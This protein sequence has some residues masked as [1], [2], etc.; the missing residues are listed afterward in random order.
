M[1]KTN[2]ERGALNMPNADTLPANGQRIEYLDYLRVIA[3]AAVVLLHISIQ[4]W[5]DV[6]V[7]SG[8]WM[9]YNVWNG[10]VRWCVPVF[11]MISGALFLNPKKKVSV[12]RLWTRN[13][14]R[15]LTAFLFWS[16]IYA[17]YH[18][19]TRSGWT[20]HTF[21]MAVLTGMVLSLFFGFLIPTLRHQV[22]PFSV[23]LAESDTI[24]ALLK[25]YDSMRIYL[26]LGYTGYFALG[27][28]LYK[29]NLT[30]GER[31]VIYVLGVAGFLLT[32]TGTAV[33]SRNLAKANS[34]WYEYVS[35]NVLLESMA[36]FVL[37]RYSSRYWKEK[38]RNL[39]TAMADKT[40][41]I[42]LI[43][44]LLVEFLADIIGLKSTLFT[45][46]LSV[47]LLA[48]LTFAVSYFAAKGLKRLGRFSRYIL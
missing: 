45:P 15:I 8:Q 47:P 24:H 35:L 46:V 6:D 34:A 31:I 44:L 9:V 7:Q 19:A 23:A 20:G 14:P 30:P 10:L 32:I 38:A 12:Y 27:Y 43:H 33:L 28:Y 40:F 3:T 29:R 17:L 2:R 41:G 26:P 4:G 37:V 22:I 25:D 48:A 42:Y 13:I 39:L 21:A 16:V 11:V 1:K 5:G 18:L 36:V